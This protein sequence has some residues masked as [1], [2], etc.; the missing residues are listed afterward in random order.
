VNDLL[1]KLYGMIQPRDPLQAATS[2]MTSPQLGM[3]NRVLGLSTQQAQTA[4]QEMP[5]KLEQSQAMLDQ[6][7]PRQPIDPRL[8]DQFMNLTGFAPMG[9]FIGPSSKLWNKQAS[10]MFRDLEKSGVSKEEAWR[11]T[12][13][14]RSPDGKLRQ[15]IDDSGSTMLPEISVEKIQENM[16]QKLYNKP[17]L[18]LTDDQTRNVLSKSLVEVARARSLKGSFEHPALYEAYPQLKRLQLYRSKGPGPT[19]SLQGTVIKMQAPSDEV[20][21]SGVLHEGQH[22]IQDI[23]RFAP[24][25]WAGEFK[26][27]VPAMLEINKKMDRLIKQITE[28]QQGVR[29]PQQTKELADLETQKFY[30]TPMGQYLRLAGEAEARAVESRINLSPEQRLQMFPLESYDVP[31][32][33]LIIRNLLD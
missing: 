24:G 30:A 27:D 16:A 3:L 26:T 15:E 8:L 10:E 31:I 32:N 6:Y 19:G 22:A 18:D 11:Q 7:D 9:I 20:M 33:Q 1:A 25:G 29:T 4:I 28:K 14:F 13:T 23:E 2:P 12:R 5:E 21:R 17:L